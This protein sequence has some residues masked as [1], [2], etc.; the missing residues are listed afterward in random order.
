MNVQDKAKLTFLSSISTSQDP[1][2]KEISAILTDEEYC[3]NQRIPPSSVDLLLKAKS[4]IST[5]STKTLSSYCRKELRERVIEEHDER[6]KELTVQ[7][8][9]LEVAELERSNQVW[10]RI[11]QGLPAG[12]LSFLL[13]AGTDTLPTPLNLRRWRLRT[14]PSCPLCGHKQPTVHHILYNCSEAL[15]QGRYTWRHDSALLVL[16]RGIQEH[17]DSDTTLYADLP[18]MQASDNPLSTIP[19]NIL[20]TS[21]RPDSVLVGK[22]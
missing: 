18:G 1:L 20:V 6:L 13:R 12:Q 3:K 10:K 19:E 5:I 11:L 8:K 15:Q 22:R 21:A 16:A 14:D 17:L 4:S 2:I 9:I 7:N